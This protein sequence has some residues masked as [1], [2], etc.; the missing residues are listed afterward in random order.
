[1]PDTTFGDLLEYSETDAVYLKDLLHVMRGKG[2]TRFRAVSKLVR[3]L[4]VETVDDP[5]VRIIDR[6]G[7]FRLHGTRFKSGVQRPVRYFLESA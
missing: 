3:H 2:D 4:R 5:R 6:S 1:M 7:T